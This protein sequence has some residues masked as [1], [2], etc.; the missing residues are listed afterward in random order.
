M[1]DNVTSESTGE[2]LGNQTKN[3]G[4]DNFLMTSFSISYNFLKHEKKEEIEEF[5]DEDIDYLAYDTEDE[6]G[7]GVIDFIDECPWTPAGVEVDEKGCPLD[8]DGDFVPNYKDDELESRD[9]V[10]V[11]PNGVEM[12]DT[13]IYIAYQKYMDSTGVFAETQTR[14]IAAEKRKK[15]KYKVQIG[16]FT[17]SR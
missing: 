15:K 16:E 10:P 11:S 5:E 6:D 12:T 13:M 1:I 3:G 9:N 7:D 2:R 14:V 8:K 17:E 4:K